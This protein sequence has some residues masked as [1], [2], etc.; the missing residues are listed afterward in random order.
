MVQHPDFTARF[1]HR[2]QQMRSR[3]GDVHLHCARCQLEL[4]GSERCDGEGLANWRAGRAIESPSPDVRDAGA[5]RHEIEDPSVEAALAS[6][7]PGSAIAILV[8]ESGPS[9]AGIDGGR[10]GLPLACR[11]AS[12]AGWLVREGCSVGRDGQKSDQAPIAATA[13]PTG[14]LA[15]VR[16]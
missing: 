12:L 13:S 5:I 2:Q 8:P 6:A 3:D 7:L 4:R 9:D 16:S 1:V 11:R 15:V 14:P 10:A